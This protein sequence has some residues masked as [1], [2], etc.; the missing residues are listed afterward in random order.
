M[1]AQL[2]E[3]IRSAQKGDQL[4]FKKLVSKYDDRV[5]RLITA[6]VRNQQDAQ[7]LYQ[8]VFII[9]WKKIN[10]YQ[11]RSDFYSWLYRIAVN[12]CYNHLKKEARHKWDE[13]TEIRSHVG[14]EDP[15]DNNKARL[16]HIITNLPPRLRTITIMYYLESN[17]IKYISRVL[18]ITEGTIKNTF[19]E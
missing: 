8:D 10:T 15:H 16:M 2:I 6:L 7:D 3:Y 1:E 11:F 13:V 9:V 18:K 12:T 5:A 14:T 19:S 4:A 17:S